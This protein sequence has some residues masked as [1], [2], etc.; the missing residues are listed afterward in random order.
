M[1][2]SCSFAAVAFCLI[3]FS[4]PSQTKQIQLRNEIIVTQPRGANASAAQPLAAQVPATGLFLL[5]FDHAVTLDERA[6]LRAEGVEL[7]KYVPQDA[8]IAKFNR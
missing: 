1:L 4:A 6:Q 5:Q 8:F 7:L 2:R 3:S